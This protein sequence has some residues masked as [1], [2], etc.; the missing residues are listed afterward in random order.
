[1]KIVR[2]R[3]MHSTSSP[4]THH[5]FQMMIRKA[6]LS[7]RAQMIMI[8]EQFRFLNIDFRLV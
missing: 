4:R 6:K 3:M 7:L 2:N 5:F 8:V 1:M